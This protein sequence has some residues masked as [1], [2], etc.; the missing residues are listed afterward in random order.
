MLA[1]G[2]NCV[3]VGQRAVFDGDGEGGALFE[4]RERGVRMQNRD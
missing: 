1:P 2:L 4:Q 3:S